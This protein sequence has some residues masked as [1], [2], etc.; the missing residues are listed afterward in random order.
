[1]L[2]KIWIKYVFYN[3]SLDGSHVK[4][5]NCFLFRKLFFLVFF[6]VLCN[7]MCGHPGW[8][9]WPR[10]NKTKMKKQNDNITGYECR[11]FIQC[12]SIVYSIWLTF[13]Q[14]ESIFCL[15]FEFEWIILDD[16]DDDED[17]PFIW[18]FNFILEN[19]LDDTSSK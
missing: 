4:L 7:V 12:E 2:K 18:L 5:K 19:I 17:Y 1:M 14:L 16:D 11:M 10:T 15:S 3:P 8:I 9:H 13:F 6:F